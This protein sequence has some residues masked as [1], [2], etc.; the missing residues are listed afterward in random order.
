MS[1]Y[2]SHLCESYPIA[3]P[4][5]YAQENGD[6]Y[7]IILSILL[8]LSPIPLTRTQPVWEHLLGLIYHHILI[9]NM[10]IQEILVA[11]LGLCSENRI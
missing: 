8:F 5:T 4:P 1:P 7:V 11:W 6:L 9:P 3:S 10:V 2:E